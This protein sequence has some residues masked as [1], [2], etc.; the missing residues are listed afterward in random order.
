MQARLGTNAYFCEE[1]VLELRAVTIDRKEG[2]NRQLV[3]DLRTRCFSFSLLSSL[4]SSD[5]KAYAPW[6]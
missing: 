3:E 6:I 5:A 2:Y 1:V 4:E